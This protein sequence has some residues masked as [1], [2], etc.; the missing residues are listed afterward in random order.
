ET[1][2]IE[3]DTL[4]EETRP[5]DS[6]KP[7]EETQPSKGE[8]NSPPKADG[9]LNDLYSKFNKYKDDEPTEITSVEEET[10]A[11]TPKEKPSSKP[12]DSPRNEPSD[13]EATTEVPE[14][15]LADN[16]PTFE[17]LEEKVRADLREELEEE[18][19][20]ELK[21]E[22]L[23]KIKAELN[24]EADE[25]EMDIIAD[26]VMEKQVELNR[27]KPNAATIKP[28]DPIEEE[29]KA[30]I[31]ADV[32]E[33]LKEELAEPIKEELKEEVVV[34][35]KEKKKDEVQQRMDDWKK[36][37][38]RSNSTP[39]TKP[40]PK[41]K[42]DPEYVEVNQNIEVVPIKVGQVIPMNNIFFEANKSSIKGQ[43]TGELERVLGFL[44]KNGS[45]IVEVG[46]HTNGWC[47]T[48]FAFE[49]SSARAKAVRKYFTDN[50]VP[51]HRIQF[52]G[53]GKTV[54]I[55]DNNTGAGRKKNQRVELKI[56][57]IID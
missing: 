10:I 19:K 56:L 1:T 38:S 6:T 37:R 5:S 29:L 39:T 26:V 32:K 50:G 27:L 35:T 23:Q 52:R 57:E 55:A 41:P 46:G 2:P 54:P 25:E 40:T 18:V 28:L 42:K 47:S 24:K 4:V 17:E 14:N 49:L 51:T 12:K 36:R 34:E 44:K 7:K 3:E 21:L 33:E 31:I 20:A 43:S 48:A 22:W 11:D 30:L 8:L 13:N 53:Y 16:Q 45:L 9:E 15:T